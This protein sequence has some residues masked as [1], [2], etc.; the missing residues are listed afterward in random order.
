MHGEP[1]LWH[2]LM[3]R[4]ADMAMAS[5]RAQIEAGAQAVQLFDSWAGSL[6]PA[7]YERFALPA[8]RGARRARRPRRAE[9]PLRRR[10]R[11]APRAD[12]AAGADVVGVDWRVPLDEAR[13]RVGAGPRGAGQPRPGAL[14]RAVAGRGRG[15]PAPS[16]RRGGGTGT[17]HVFNLGHGVLPETDPGILAAVVDLVHAESRAGMTRGVLVMAHGTRRARP[18]SRP[19]TRASAGAARRR[20]AAGRAGGRYDAIGGVSPLAERTAAQVDAVARRPRGAATR[21]ATP[22][23]SAPSTPTPSS[24]R[25]PPTLAAAGLER[26]VGLV[27]TPHCSSLGSEEYLDRAAGALGDRPF[28]PVPPWYAAAGARRPPGRPRRRT[29]CGTGAGRANGRSSPRTRCPSAIRETGDPYPE[30]VAESARLVAAGRRARRVARGLA[31]RRPHPRALARARR[32]RRRAPARRRR[33]RPTRSSSARSASWRTTSRCS[34]TSTSSWRRSRRRAASPSPA[35]R[36]STTT[37]R[38]SRRWPS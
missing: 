36:R 7:D 18:R 12:G 29:R 14:P 11:G 13:R 17:G 38:S 6:S 2:Q 24:R 19:S 35:R 3:D 22:C 1:A 5:L 31:E 28:V 15:H 21:A 33:R 32:P 25:P 23:R 9:H 16:S 37:P 27:L 26:V 10:H 20:R 30:Q 4:L 34:T 8:T